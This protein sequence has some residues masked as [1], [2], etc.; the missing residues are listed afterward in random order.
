M[1]PFAGIFLTL[2]F[3]ADVLSG[4]PGTQAELQQ[5]AEAAMRTDIKEINHRLVQLGAGGI[6]QFELA[7]GPVVYQ[8]PGSNVADNVMYVVRNTKNPGQYTVGIAGTNFKSS[9]DWLVE[10]GLVSWTVPWHSGQPS[11]GRI[12]LGTATGLSILQ[13]LTAVP[14]VGGTTQSVDVMTYLGQQIGGGDGSVYVTGHSLGGALSPVFG[15]WL[16]E[17]KASWGPKAD[18]NVYLFAGPTPGDQTFASYYKGRLGGTTHSHWNAN[19]VVPHAWSQ[20]TAPNLSQMPGLYEDFPA[21]AKVTPGPVINGLIGVLEAISQGTDYTAVS[22]APA[23]FNT[24][25]VNADVTSCKS[26][27]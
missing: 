25:D 26:N 21:D 14:H 4:A 11:A 7:W 20:Q 12:A 13:S 19:D 18:V 6:F 15:L 8:A 27:L 9:F 22:S 16:D 1:D 2:A 24:P 3:L 17:N 10:D 5:K 23:T